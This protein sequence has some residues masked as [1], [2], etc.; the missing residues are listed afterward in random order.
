M[1]SNLGDQSF[2]FFLPIKDGTILATFQARSM[3]ATFKKKKKDKLHDVA[4][5]SAISASSCSDKCPSELI[6]YSSLI[7]QVI[8]TF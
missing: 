8:L 2:S 6:L 3:I 1:T 4:I 5:A 7:S